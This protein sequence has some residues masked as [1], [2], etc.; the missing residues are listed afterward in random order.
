MAL[1]AFVYTLFA[2]NVKKNCAYFDIA[3]DWL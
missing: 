3:H 2:G 1:P